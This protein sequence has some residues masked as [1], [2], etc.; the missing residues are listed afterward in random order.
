MAFGDGQYRLQP[1]YVDDLAK[2]AVQQGESRENVTIDATGPETFTYRELAQEVGRIIGKRR[3]I[4]SIPPS[5][6]Y[7]ASWVM[8]KILGDVL[9]TRDEITG[10]MS[11]LLYTQSP[12]AGTTKLTEWLAQHSDTIGRKYASELG[13]RKKR[14]TI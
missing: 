3:P 11:N 4:L 14:K 13:R 10:L 2:L 7:L 9:V 6:G 8:G 1:I 5:M 12:P